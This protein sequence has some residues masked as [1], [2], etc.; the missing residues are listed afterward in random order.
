VG[1]SL[2]HPRTPYSLC[3]HDVS[4][5]QNPPVPCHEQEPALPIAGWCRMHLWISC[6]DPPAYSDIASVGTTDNH[7]ICAAGQEFGV[8]LLTT[9]PRVRFW[10]VSCEIY[11]RR[12]GT[13]AGLYPRQHHCTEAFYWYNHDENCALLGYYAD[14]SGSFL[15]T[16]RTTYWSHLQLDS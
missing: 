3:R 11:D 10:L 15:P 7:C 1:D 8:R 4:M 12:N 6:N 5:T 13:R 16:F 2:T 9:E 14:R